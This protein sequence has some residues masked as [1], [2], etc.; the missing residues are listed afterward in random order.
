MSI[1]GF[2]L[3]SWQRAGE[4]AQVRHGLPYPEPT[5]NPIKFYWERA[6]WLQS[7]VTGYPTVIPLQNDPWARR[8]AWRYS[9]P[10]AANTRR[11]KGTFP[12]LGIATGAFALYLAY[13]MFVAEK[14]HGEGHH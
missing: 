5:W 13:D 7:I 2:D 9:G 14:E 10:F 11:W 3:V 6:V 12:G 4:V 8:E 1:T